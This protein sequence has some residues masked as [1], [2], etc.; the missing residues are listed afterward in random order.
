MPASIEQQI[1]K[2]TGMQMRVSIPLP[3]PLLDNTSRKFAT[4][5]MHIPDQFRVDMFEEE[6]REKWASGRE[7]F[8]RL[9]TMVLPNDHLTGESP[10]TGYPFQE[11]YM[12]DNDLALARVVQFLSR[13]SYWKSMQGVEAVRPWIRL[14]P[15]ARFSRDGRSG[16]HAE[17]LRGGRPPQRNSPVAGE[18]RRRRRSRRVWSKYWAEHFVPKNTRLLGRIGAAMEMAALLC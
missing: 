7:P 12:A 15:A 9:I 16:R 11:S 18:V 2:Y 1:H 13:T 10:A 5:N 8:P 6:Y 14:V 3:K 17:R 4:F